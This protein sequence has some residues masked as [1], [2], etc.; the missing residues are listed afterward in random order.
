MKLR[1]RLASL[2]VTTLMICPQV[3]SEVSMAYQT[4]QADQ[5]DDTWHYVQEDCDNSDTESSSNKKSA[6]DAPATSGGDWLQDGSEANQVAQKIFDYWTDELGVSGAFASSILANIQGESGFISDIG[7]GGARLG[8]NN[9]HGT[10]FNSANPGALGGGG[11]YQFTPYTKFSE[12]EYWGKLDPEGWNFKN[13]TQFV[14]DTEFADKSVFRYYTLNSSAGSSIPGGADAG[15][16]LGQFGSLEDALS[17]DDPAK[18]VS[19]FQLGYER[20]AVYHTEREEW[21]KQANAKFNSAHK[22]A[23]KSKWKFKDG[24]T[25]S[26]DSNGSTS[27]KE[28][29]KRDSCK[30]KKESNAS[31]WGEDGTGQ[32]PGAHFWKREDLPDDMKKYAIDLESIGMS[33][34]NPNGWCSSGYE[35]R[36]GQCVDLSRAVIKNLWQKDGKQGPIENA[37]SNG[38]DLA[39]TIASVYGGKVTDTPSAGAVAGCE[40]ITVYGHTFVVSHVFENG[41]ILVVEQNTPYSGDTISQ[42]ATWDYRVLT[43]SEYQQKHTHFFNPQ[44]VGYTVNPSVKMLA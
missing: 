11:L 27:I 24:S 25:S 31:G 43:K 23:N 12:S 38:I 4:V 20:P 18:A 1:K 40:D 44:S 26:T 16:R 14:W 13:Q 15:S 29:E 10:T 2:T 19:V 35:G 22:K 7:E 33:W 6:G 5:K 8:M 41:D 30:P 28:S 36:W 21:A 34:G 17:T 42:P 3:L 39:D 37:S 9:Q 32:S